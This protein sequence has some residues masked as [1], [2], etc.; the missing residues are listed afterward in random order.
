MDVFVV[1]LSFAIGAG[2]TQLGHVIA[3][4][5]RVEPSCTWCATAS[6]WPVRGHETRLC[7]GFVLE[8]RERHPEYGGNLWREPAAEQSGAAW[9]DVSRANRLSFVA[10]PVDR[11]TEPVDDTE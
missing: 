9:V 5:L 1:L 8:Q 10:R 3:R 4:Q 6:G 11:D 7:R 2:L